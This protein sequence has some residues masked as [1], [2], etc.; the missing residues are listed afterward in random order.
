MLRPADGCHVPTPMTERRRKV[1]K[2]DELERQRTL[3]WIATWRRAGPELERIRR[4][5]IRRSDTAVAVALL[6]DVTA[7]ALR[8]NPPKSWSGLVEQQAVFMRGRS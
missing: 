8:M 2:M 5:E 3:E 1:F 6:E 7:A 4:D